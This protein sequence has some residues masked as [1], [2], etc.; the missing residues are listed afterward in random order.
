[1]YREQSLMPLWCM[2]SEVEKKGRHL[3]A[4]GDELSA[5]DMTSESSCGHMRSDRRG[6]CNGSDGHLRGGVGIFRMLDRWFK[7]QNVAT[8]P[9]QVH[10]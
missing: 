6:D 7:H 2:P 8:I 3:V 4:E 9:F 5:Q 10:L 1:M